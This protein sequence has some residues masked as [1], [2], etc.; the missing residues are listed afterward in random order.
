[1]EYQLSGYLIVDVWDHDNLNQDDFL[2]QVMLPLRDIPVFNPHEEWYPLT[3]RSAKE[4]VSGS[5]L[6]EVQLKMD[7][8]KV[9]Q[10]RYIACYVWGEEGEWRERGEGRR[11][12]QEEEGRGRR[13]GLEG[14]EGE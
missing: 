8:N 5:I 2:G 3:R 13:Q 1:V 7:R 11:E 9:G 4:K 6:L 10:S 12:R 14:G